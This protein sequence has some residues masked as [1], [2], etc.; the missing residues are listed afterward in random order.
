MLPKTINQNLMHN[1]IAGDNKFTHQPSDTIW[2]HRCGPKLDQAMA[3]C[4]TA[5]S[6]YLNQCWLMIRKVRWHS[7]KGNFEGSLVVL[8]LYRQSQDQMPFHIF[9]CLNCYIFHNITVRRIIFHS[10]AHKKLL[11]AGDTNNNRY[12]LPKIFKMTKQLEKRAKFGCPAVT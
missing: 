2:Q 8:S 7:P 6:H 5:P 9:W 1:C 12:F 11:C 4:L 10:C 3:C